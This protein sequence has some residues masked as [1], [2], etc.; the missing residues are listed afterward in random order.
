MKAAFCSGM[1]F[2]AALCLAATFAEAKDMPAIG[3]A[4]PAAGEKPSQAQ[5]TGRGDRGLALIS[6]ASRGDV[7]GV[8]R[9]LDEGAGVDATDDRG[10]TALVA[11][12]YGNHV[13][14]ARL[15]IGAGADVNRQDRTRQSAYLISTSEGFLELLRLTLASGADVHR[16]DRYNGTGLIRAADRGHVEIVRELLKTDIRL[17]HVNDLGWT[18]LLEVIILGD[19]D[20]RRAEIVRLLLEAG[21]D[22]NR[23]DANGVSPLAH[24]KH[25]GF[26]E[27]AT[28]LEKHGARRAPP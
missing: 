24:A 16:T 2:T 14:A 27:I 9:L 22:P 25:R 11:A 6:A 10:V 17:D 26:G 20:A 3:I 23:A 15:L 28:I 4:A 12:A 18:A 1:A 13:E 8:R 5:E 7:S 21:A 19:G